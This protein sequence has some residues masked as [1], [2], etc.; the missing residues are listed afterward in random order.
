MI[1]TTG[2]KRKTK[3]KKKKNCT[4]RR[5]SRI[6]NSTDACETCVFGCEPKT[7]TKYSIV[8]WL[9]QMTSFILVSCFVIFGTYCNLLTQHVAHIT[10]INVNLRLNYRF[11]GGSEKVIHSIIA[12][13]CFFLS[14][15]LSI[16]IR[17]HYDVHHCRH[18]TWTEIDRTTT[19][20][21]A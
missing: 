4:S 17:H 12:S 7:T 19:S 10:K 3:R 14:S 2:T 1:K 16:C 20:R 11:M 6:V 8:E 15:F 21:T 18:L 13:Y 5:N 9:P